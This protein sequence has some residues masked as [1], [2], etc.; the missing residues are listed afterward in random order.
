MTTKSSRPNIGSSNSGSFMGNKNEQSNSEQAVNNEKMDISDYIT[1]G[2]YILI[3]LMLLFVLGR[4]YWLTHGG[5]FETFAFWETDNKKWFEVFF[6]SL[7]GSIAQN[8]GRGAYKMSINT[9]QKREILLQFARIIESP[10]ITLALIF[11]L[12]NVGVAFGETTISLSETPPPVVI[13]FTIVA[14][15]FAWHTKNALDEIARSFI[16]RISKSFR[17]S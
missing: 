6:W 14:S 13:A 4:Y 11:I 3:S 17:A 10:F 15:Y 2:I 9:F 5:S 7:F 8:T 16:G 1:G 12:F